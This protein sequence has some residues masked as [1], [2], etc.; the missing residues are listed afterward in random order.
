MSQIGFGIRKVVL[1]L[2][3][4]FSVFWASGAEGT[5]AEMF[6]KVMGSGWE[7]KREHPGY[8]RVDADALEIRIEPGN[9][10]GPA[11]D[12]RNVLVKNLGE[13]PRISISMVVSN[14][15]TEQYEQ[16]DLVCY[17]DDGHMV[18]IGQELVDGQLSIVMGREEG[19]KTQTIKIVPIDLQEVELRL[20]VNEK[21]VMGAFRKPGS[22][23]WKEVGECDLPEYGKLNASIQCYQGPGQ[24]EHWG[25]IKNFQVIKDE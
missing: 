18:K 21:R 9:M 25:R 14:K 4:C 22:S 1:G 23:E 7:W 6:G 2:A 10:W 24:V 3:I 19:D 5:K 17:Y 16:M 12:A 20:R 11:N 15:P 13:Q 8:W